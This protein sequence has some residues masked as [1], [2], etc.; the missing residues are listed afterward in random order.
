MAEKLFECEWTPEG[1]IIL[2]IKKPGLRLLTPEVR[3]HMLGARK[4]MLSA[5]RSLIDAALAR[6][7]EKEA[8][9][10]RR[11]QIKVE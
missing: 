2:R 10:T 7:D 1:E 9:R 6:M 3:G 4:E 8:P 11:T 5:L